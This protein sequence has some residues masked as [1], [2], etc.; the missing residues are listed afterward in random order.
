M[1]GLHYQV[2]F[3]YTDDLNNHHV[4]SPELDDIDGTQKYVVDVLDW[5][6]YTQVCFVDLC[7]KGKVLFSIEAAEFK[8]ILNEYDDEFGGQ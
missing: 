4:S 3:I 5:F 8:R 1:K 6:G 2:R 7:Y